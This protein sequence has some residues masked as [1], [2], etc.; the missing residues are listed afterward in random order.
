MNT[1]NFNTKDDRKPESLT[2]EE[3]MS[4]D[5]NWERY[6]P[7]SYSSDE[8]YMN[9]PVRF[10]VV[11]VEIIDN[12]I[13][14]RIADGVLHDSGKCGYWDEGCDEIW[15]DFYLDFYQLEKGGE[16]RCGSSIWFEVENHPDV[17]PN[18]LAYGIWLNDKQKAAFVKWFTDVV[19]PYNGKTVLEIFDEA[20]SEMMDRYADSLF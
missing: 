8:M 12:S 1:H 9:Y 18:V 7:L 5:I 14:N 15:Y 10:P 6:E 2:A 13:L 3:I 16:I 20:R 19:C 4:F 17:D 11:S